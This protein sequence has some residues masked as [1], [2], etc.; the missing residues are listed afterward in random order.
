LEPQDIV[1]VTVKAP[2][3][4]TI[5][6]GIA[7]LLHQDSLVVFVGNGIPWWYFHGHGGDLEGTQLPRLDPGRSLWKRIG[8]ER[9][10]GAVAYTACTVLAPGVIRAE[11]PR[12]RLIVGRPDGRLD[13]RLET[14]ASL[15]TPSG[16]EVEITPRLRDAIWAKLTNNLVGGSL[17]VLTDSP[18]KDVLDKP[19]VAATAEAMA[20]ESAAVARAFGCDPGD[21][22]EVLAKQA[23]SGHVQSVVQD[24]R[25]GRPM[26]VD[27]LFRVPLDLAALAGV[28]TP[29]L[30]VVVEL[31]IQRARATGLYLDGTA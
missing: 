20:H 7:S 29:T 15:L 28:P 23:T 6:E 24:L 16:L 19:A 13:G 12:N 9:T 2:A 27:A 31:A 18:M 8:P 1:L 4:P 10:A 26:E 22:A 3:L 25:A 14:L 5:A 17:G 30:D 21:V 11:N